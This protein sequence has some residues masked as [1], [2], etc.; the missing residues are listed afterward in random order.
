[1]FGDVLLLVSLV[2][3]DM[4]THQH[5][6][7]PLAQTGNDARRAANPEG[8]ELCPAGRF[9]HA[10]QFFEVEAGVVPELRQVK[11]VRKLEHFGS[12]LPDG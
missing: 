3:L 7:R 10:M 1:M 9:N 12:R 2:V 4:Q 11:G 5:Q 8:I 6:G